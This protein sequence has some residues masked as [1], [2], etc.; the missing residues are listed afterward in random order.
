MK[1]AKRTGN[2]N[3]PPKK[4]LICLNYSYI[5][6]NFII[7]SIMG[8]DS[9]DAFNK[10]SVV[11]G[12]LMLSMI[13]ISYLDIRPEMHGNLNTIMT[14]I[15]HFCSNMYLAYMYENWQYIL[16]YILEALISV[17]IW[18]IWLKIFKRKDNKNSKFP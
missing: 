7:S 16:F 9:N 13:P 17:S 4:L 12:I 14:S 2:V 8:N 10:I 18:F 6:A 5:G 3:C 11:I 1:K 15:L